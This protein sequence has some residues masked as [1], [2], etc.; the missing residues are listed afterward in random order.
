MNLIRLTIKTTI[1]RPLIMGVPAIL[2]LLLITLNSYNPL[3]PIFM[4][5]SNATGTS[6]FEGLIS[7]LQLLLEPDILPLFILGIIGAAILGSL[8]ISVIFSGYLY[9]LYNV[10]KGIA[11]TPGDYLKGI[12]KY[13]I[14]VFGVTIRAAGFS[15]FFGAFIMVACVPAVIITRAAAATRPD[16]LPAAIFVDI[17]TVMVMFFS[18]MFT[19]AYLLY[20]YPSVF[21]SVTGSFKRAKSFADKHFWQIVSR[22]LAFDIVFILFEVL[23]LLTGVLALQLLFNLI[24]C[25]VFFTV[26]FLYV[27]VSY[28]NM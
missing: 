7:A 10:L 26:F 23:I 15:I 3:L 12:R 5:L 21:E 16:F 1:K 25:S 22:F 20:W 14:R 6:I 9:V 17:L 28:T 8:F 18:L 11:K 24:F 19:R 27:V 2:A 4:G 13:F